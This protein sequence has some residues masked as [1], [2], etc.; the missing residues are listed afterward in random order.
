MK[1]ADIKLGKTCVNRGAGRIPR[2]I[3]NALRRLKRR[4]ELPMKPKK[5][6]T[7]AELTAKVLTLEAQQECADGIIGRLEGRIDELEEHRQRV[8]KWMDAEKIIFIEPLP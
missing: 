5:K 2:L 4:G 3:H 1:T 6:L 8:Q 7:V